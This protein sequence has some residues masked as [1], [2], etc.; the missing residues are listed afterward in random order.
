MARTPRTASRKVLLRQSAGRMHHD[1]AIATPGEACSGRARG[2][3]DVV[4][5]RRPGLRALISRRGALVGVSD[6]SPTRN[7][8]SSIQRVI[9]RWAQWQ[10]WKG[11]PLRLLS[12]TS[13]SLLGL[14]PSTG[15]AFPATGSSSASSSSLLLSPDDGFLCGIHRPR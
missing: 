1:T 8:T 15:Y 7:S 11:N 13:P 10:N 12:S 9:T 14:Y 3:S 5:K 4:A 2:G 6:H